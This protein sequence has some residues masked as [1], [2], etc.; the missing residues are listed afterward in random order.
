MALSLSAAIDLLK[1]KNMPTDTDKNCADI[2]DDFHQFIIL[3]INR[4]GDLVAE[5]QGKSKTS[6]LEHNSSNAH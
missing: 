5:K 6:Q 4:T 2:T 3:L 1:C